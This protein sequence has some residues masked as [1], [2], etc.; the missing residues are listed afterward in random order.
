MAGHRL[1]RQSAHCV[2]VILVLDAEALIQGGV[3]QVRDSARR[4]DI[5]IARAQAAVHANTVVHF[6]SRCL[7]EFHV[8]LD[9][10][11]RDHGIR[12]DFSIALVLLV[13][14]FQYGLALALFPASHPFA[15]QDFN[16]FLTIEIVQELGKVGR[17]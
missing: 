6:Q 11:S 10:N 16:P 4:V 13:A 9:P 8:G 12:D 15:G 5:G 7:G 17:K 3:V 2:G 1:T 14:G